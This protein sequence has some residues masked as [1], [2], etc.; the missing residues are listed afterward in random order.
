M[1]NLGVKD[2]TF[3]TMSGRKVDLIIF[4]APGNCAKTCC[5]MVSLKAAMQSD[6]E[7]FGREYDL[8]LH[9]VVVMGDL[10]FDTME[11]ML[12]KIY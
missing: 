3:T 6:E 2:D 12:L 4:T 7:R 9:N 8:D 11:K 5:A 1:G 10:D